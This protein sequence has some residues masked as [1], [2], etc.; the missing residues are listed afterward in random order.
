M[1]HLVGEIFK[2]AVKPLVGTGIGRIKLIADIY[3]NIVC[4]VLDNE[5]IINVQG[6]KV[7]IVNKDHIG[8][9]A[10]ELLFSGVHE[11]ASTK[12]FKD[13]VKKGNCVID[14]GANIGYFTLLSSMLVGEY[15]RVFCFEPDMNNLDELVENIE[16]NGFKNIR[17]SLLAISNYNGRSM[18]YLSST[19]S[20]R[21]YHNNWLYTSQHTHNMCCRSIRNPFVI[22][23]DSLCLP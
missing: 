16:I 21:H 5:Q 23:I 18:F 7:K 1:T 4:R 2:L 20:A 17:P 10:T 6:F 3:Q 9:I 8:D 19:E 15:G 12:V 13:V 11:A 22:L 14:I